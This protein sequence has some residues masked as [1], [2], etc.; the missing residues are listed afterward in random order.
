MGY[1]FGHNPFEQIRD[2]IN[3]IEAHAHRSAGLRERS[4]EK[5]QLYKPRNL[6]SASLLFGPKL[7]IEQVV[8]RIIETT[9][10]HPNCDRNH[11]L[12]HLQYLSK[13]RSGQYQSSVSIYF[14]SYQRSVEYDIVV[15]NGLVNSDVFVANNENALQYNKFED[16]QHELD[17]LYE[18]I[19]EFV[20]VLTEDENSQLMNLLRHFVKT[21][22]ENSI[23][24]MISGGTL[25]G[26]F[27]HHARIPWDDDI[28]VYVRID[29]R[30]K[31]TRLLSRN[32]YVMHDVGE[33]YDKVCHRV[34]PK[35]ANSQLW[36]WPFIDIGYLKRNTTHV[37]EWRSE[38]NR[39]LAHHVFPISTIYPITRR[40]YGQLNLNA[41]NN[42]KAFLT[43]QFTNEKW[44]SICARPNYDHRLERIYKPKFGTSAAMIRVNCSIL[45]KIQLVDVTSNDHTSAS[46]HDV[47]ILKERG[48]IIVRVT[49]PV[50]LVGSYPLR[51]S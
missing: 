38:I 30:S 4:G 22:E 36:N 16:T 44:Y 24:Y 49:E 21:C 5:C 40:P 10:R 18:K 27:L 2:E 14:L 50:A 42:P 43:Q 32:D 35:V 34:G 51:T 7:A 13:A 33:G 1:I 17:D 26:S 20:E 25:V 12:T 8:K 29:D 48:R 28:D 47:E 11:I 31:L 46:T 23:E 6:L 45:P 19:L 9:R 3:V 15:N 39:N 41:P 37:W